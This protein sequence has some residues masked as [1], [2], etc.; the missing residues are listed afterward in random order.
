MG[1]KECSDNLHRLEKR[2]WTFLTPTHLYR[3]G[4]GPKLEPPFLLAL[5]DHIKPRKLE[6]QETAQKIFRTRPC[7]IMGSMFGATPGGFTYTQSVEAEQ[8]DDE[9][10]DDMKF[11]DE[12]LEYI[13]LVLLSHSVFQLSLK[14]TLL[15]SCKGGWDQSKHR[16]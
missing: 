7:R 2:G 10:K 12:A 14:N 13:V 6:K 15:K 5:S 9:E 1:N 3:F 16:R 11:N 4:F 8:E